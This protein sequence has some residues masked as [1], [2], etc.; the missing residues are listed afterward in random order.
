MRSKPIARGYASPTDSVLAKIEKAVGGGVRILYDP[1]SDTDKTKYV[2]RG[3]ITIFDIGVGPKG[4]E[5]RAVVVEKFYTGG[6]GACTFL[7]FSRLDA[8]QLGTE[9]L[10]SVINTETPRLI[11]K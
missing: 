2:Q 11:E 10:I 3:E 4:N 6:G 9:G 8:V 5:R 1:P 7:I